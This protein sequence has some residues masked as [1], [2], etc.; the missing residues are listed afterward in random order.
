VRQ[1]WPT[2][3]PQL[4]LLWPTRQASFAPNLSAL[5]LCSSCRRC[6][7]R[8]RCDDRAR[9]DRR[10]P[11]AAAAL[12]WSTFWSYIDHSSAGVAFVCRAM[13]TDW[14]WP[15]VRR[16]PGASHPDKAARTRHRVTSQLLA[17]SPATRGLGCRSLHLDCAAPPLIGTRPA[18]PFEAVACCR[19]SASAI[20]HAS[21]PMNGEMG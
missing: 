14:L 15:P 10:R 19:R 6:D 8:P 21:L 11:P 4:S 1:S 12:L 20:T 18:R 3:Q 5:L 7:S 9:A 2:G 17:A 16:S 13:S